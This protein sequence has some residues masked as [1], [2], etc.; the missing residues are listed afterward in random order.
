MSNQRTNLL[1]YQSGSFAPYKSELHVHSGC[2]FFI[3]MKVKQFMTEETGILF[4]RA[5]TVV[6][7]YSKI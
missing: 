7:F 6:F 1:A 2:A 3:V 5:Y 4:N